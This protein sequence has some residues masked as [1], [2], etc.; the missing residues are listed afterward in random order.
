MTAT[1]LIDAI[2]CCILIVGY[3]IFLIGVVKGMK[4]LYSK[5]P[6]SGNEDMVILLMIIGAT[7]FFTGGILALIV[8]VAG[9][10]VSS[11]VG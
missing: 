7:L 3:T 11:I 4:V 2:I 6:I 1:Q 8:G 9:C 10:Y 5:N